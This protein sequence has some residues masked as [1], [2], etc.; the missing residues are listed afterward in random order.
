MY[1][2]DKYGYD[3]CIFIPPGST[4]STVFCKV[5]FLSRLQQNQGELHSDVLKRCGSL[6]RDCF[7]KQDFALN[8]RFCDA[9]EFE[10]A[11]RD[12]TIPDEFFSALFDFDFKSGIAEPW[13][14]LDTGQEDNEFADGKLRKIHSVYQVKFNIVNNG[15][16]RTP[17]HMMNSEAIYNACRS[18]TLISSLNRFGLATSYDEVLRYHYDIVSY[19]I[20]ASQDKVALPS[21]FHPG[22]FTV[23]AFDKFDHEKVTLSGIGGFH[24]AVSILMQDKPSGTLTVGKPNMSETEVT[25]RER[26][27]KQELGCQVLKKY[28]IPAKKPDLSTLCEVQKDLYK[29]NVCQKSDTALKDAAWM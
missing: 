14:S 17:M 13:E 20:Q 23:G 19:V 3:M 29:A 25:H 16:K 26:Q 28:M 27:F 4:F 6:L 2:M 21:Q 10:K 12:I 7:M 24:D 5:S 18:K 1:L 9:I 11:Y 8:D 15:R 22:R